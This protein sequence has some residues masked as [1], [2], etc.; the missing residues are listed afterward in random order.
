M[1]KISLVFFTSSSIIFSDEAYKSTKLSKGQTLHLTYQYPTHHKVSQSHLFLPHQHHRGSK[2][3]CEYS[4]LSLKM[5]L[6]Y[7]DKKYFTYH[8]S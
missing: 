1:I 3:C 2:E 8:F 7:L 6:V 4:Y 5:S